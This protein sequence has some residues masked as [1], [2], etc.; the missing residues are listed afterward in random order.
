METILEKCQKLNFLDEILLV[1]VDINTTNKQV[2]Q[3]KAKSMVECN[4]FYI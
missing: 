3:F 2:H 1:A 4:F